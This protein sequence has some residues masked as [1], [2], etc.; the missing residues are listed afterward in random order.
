MPLYPYILLLIAIPL[1]RILL[2]S[3]LESER[4]EKI[5]LF[6]KVESTEKKMLVAL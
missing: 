6:G 5:P 2:R 3:R 1:G 4:E